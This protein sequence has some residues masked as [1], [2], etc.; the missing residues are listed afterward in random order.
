MH[1]R[2]G[3][4][5]IDRAKTIIAL[6]AVPLHDVVALGIGSAKVPLKMNVFHTVSIY[7]QP[8]TSFALLRF[9]FLATLFCNNCDA[10]QRALYCSVKH[11]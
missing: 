10:R 8:G 7:A 5:N 3:E 6:Q 4:V 2:G 11:S 1:S 9:S